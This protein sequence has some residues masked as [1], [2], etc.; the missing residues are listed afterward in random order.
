MLF[1][2]VMC[3]GVVPCILSRS[4]LVTL[5]TW[6][7]IFRQPRVSR[8]NFCWSLSKSLSHRCWC[9]WPGGSTLSSTLCHQS[10]WCS[11][12]T[13]ACC[14]TPGPLPRSQLCHCVHF[15]RSACWKTGLFCSRASGYFLPRCSWKVGWAD[16]YQPLLPIARVG[17]FAGVGEFFV[18]D[19]VIVIHIKLEPITLGACIALWAVRTHW[20]GLPQLP[21]PTGCRQSFFY[22]HYITIQILTLHTTYTAYNIIR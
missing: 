10:S 17:L 16:F 19:I 5:L 2:L 9:C 1:H 3:A 7:S 6:L 21:L 22:L 20:T 4:A 14:W 8:G 11:W 15:R 12:F 13:M 18:F